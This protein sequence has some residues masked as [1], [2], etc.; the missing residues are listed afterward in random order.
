MLKASAI[1]KNDAKHN[2]FVL[3]EGTLSQSSA[4]LV[5]SDMA[6]QHYTESR[7]ALSYVN[8]AD[9]RYKG[10]AKGAYPK[11]NELSKQKYK[12]ELNT[13]D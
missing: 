2:S 5:F 9:T 12:R 1:V 13:I 11:D 4:R 10:L 6:Q 8:A 3:V 7:A